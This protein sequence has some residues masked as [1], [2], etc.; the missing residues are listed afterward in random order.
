MGLVMS[1]VFSARGSAFGRVCGCRLLRT[2]GRYGWSMTISKSLEGVLV[3]G[4]MSGGTV[5]EFG[6][7]GDG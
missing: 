7:A 4:E 6:C 5:R 1:A 2:L 3:F